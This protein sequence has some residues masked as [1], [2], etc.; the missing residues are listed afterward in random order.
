MF[1][2]LDEIHCIDHIT[3]ATSSQFIPDK[4]KEVEE[5]DFVL[6]TEPEDTNSDEVFIPHRRSKRKIKNLFP[7]DSNQKHSPRRTRRRVS[8]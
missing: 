1:V 2:F 4:G 7:V 8:K 3:M 5:A 6:E